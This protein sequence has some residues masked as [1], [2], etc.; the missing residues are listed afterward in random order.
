[1]SI[2]AKVGILGGIVTP[3]IFRVGRRG[4]LNVRERIVK[5]FAMNYL[6]VTLGG[7]TDRIRSRGVRETCCNREVVY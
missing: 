7:V 4:G 3:S 6:R 5:M 1:M 2:D